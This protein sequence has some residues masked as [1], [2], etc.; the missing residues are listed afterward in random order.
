MGTLMKL[1]KRI[2]KEHVRLEREIAKNY[3]VLAKETEIINTQDAIR[4]YDAYISTLKSI[5]KSCDNTVD[6]DA[7]KNS[8][9][10]KSPTTTNAHKKSLED[11]IE[12]LTSKLNDYKP[13]FF[14][15]LFKFTESNKKKLAKKIEDL[16][17][18]LP[19]AIAKDDREYQVL[20]NQYLTEL[21][22]CE[23]QKNLA[24]GVLNKDADSLTEAFILLDTFDYI[25]HFGSSIETDFYQPIV[26]IRFNVNN[27]D[28][29][30][31]F[32]LSKTAKGKISKKVIPKGQ[33]LEIYQDFVCGCV[34]RIARDLFAN[35]PIDKVLINVYGDLSDSST[36][37]RVETLILSLIIQ[38]QILNNLNFHNLDPSDSMKNFEH[39]MKFSKSTGFQMVQEVTYSQ[40]ININQTK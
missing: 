27:S 24:I 39:K 23:K 20:Y 36:G 8:P 17:L 16:Q 19:T 34:L 1:V 32:T 21:E 31:T 38:K 6:W 13:S 14:E 26:K 18:Q 25:T 22:N 33:F 3:K 10:P 9:M 4:Q 37:H 40:T 2:E 29:I 28:V 35:A 5:H 15:N 7:I 12:L 30:P 11:K